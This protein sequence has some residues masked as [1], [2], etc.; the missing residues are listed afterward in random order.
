M[1]ACQY[2]VDAPPQVHAVQDG[3]LGLPIFQVGRYLHAQMEV[4]ILRVTDMYA[5]CAYRLQ[6]DL[7]RSATM[8]YTWRT[9]PVTADFFLVGRSSSLA[10]LSVH[11]PTPQMVT[12]PSELTAGPSTRSQGMR[13]L[14]VRVPQRRTARE[15][16]LSGQKPCA[17]S[18]TFQT[19]SL[20][21]HRVPGALK[22]LQEEEGRIVAQTSY[23][24]SEKS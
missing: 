4:P 12:S 2:D 1:A 5:R 22:G 18:S 23:R 16:A 10:L 3:A 17:V 8:I 6:K 20:P 13:A 21:R 9:Q 14:A 15:R 11:R 7:L 24:A 19:L